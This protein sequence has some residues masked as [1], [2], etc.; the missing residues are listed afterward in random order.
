LGA[1]SHILVYF[2]PKSFYT[3]Y[4][5]NYF[6]KAVEKIS[7]YVPTSI[8][9]NWTQLWLEYAEAKTPEA[10]ALKQLDKLVKFSKFIIYFVFLGEGKN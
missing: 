3:F 7:G 1:F 10:K 9:E 8:G 5:K 4:F 6:F 2:L